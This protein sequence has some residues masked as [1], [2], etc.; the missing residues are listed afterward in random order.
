MLT[1]IMLSF[2]EVT[3]S[4]LIFNVFFY[5][6]ETDSAILSIISCSLVSVPVPGVLPESYIRMDSEQSVSYQLNQ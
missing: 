6:F 4:H 1:G 3:E 2:R 5:V